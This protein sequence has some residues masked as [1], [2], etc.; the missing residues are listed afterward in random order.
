MG[1]RSSSGRR[2]EEGEGEREDILVPHTNLMIMT[3][4]NADYPKDR[5]SSGKE[6]KPRERCLQGGR[7]LPVDEKNMGV[8]ELCLA[9]VQIQISL[10]SSGRANWF[11]P[12][13]NKNK[14]ENQ[15]K[16]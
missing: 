1:S 8:W 13:T 9:P 4:E 12:T 3:R 11:D 14:Q 2:P 15:V 7:S 6:T 5:S 16:L 10:S